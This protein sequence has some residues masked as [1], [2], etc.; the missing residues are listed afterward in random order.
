[1]SIVS[2]EGASAGMISAVTFY[3]IGGAKVNQLLKPVVLNLL[4]KRKEKFLMRV[5][6]NGPFLII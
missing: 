5:K 6:Y 4:D 3:I 1:M 2:R